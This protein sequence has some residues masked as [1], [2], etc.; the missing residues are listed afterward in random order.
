MKGLHM[1]FF[2]NLAMTVAAI[3]FA[4]SVS[5]HSGGHDTLMPIIKPSIAD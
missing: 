5:A 3:F 4:L 1:R 2:S